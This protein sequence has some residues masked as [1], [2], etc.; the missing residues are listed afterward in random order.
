MKIHRCE[1]GW[2]LLEVSDEELSILEDA[3]MTLVDE[4]H[5]EGSVSSDTLRMEGCLRAAIR[6]PRDPAHR[7][8][9]A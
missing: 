7:T 6:A 8:V 3:C 9:S 5:C 2:A 1:D 4:Q